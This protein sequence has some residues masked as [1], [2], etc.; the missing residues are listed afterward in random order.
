[1]PRNQESAEEQIGAAQAVERQGESWAKP[2]SVI[3]AQLACPPRS[4]VPLSSPPSRSLASSGTPDCIHF[5]RQRLT[6]RTL[7]P[8]FPLAPT[9][10][11]NTSAFSSLP[12]SP[13][14]RGTTVALLR[15]LLAPQQPL[16]LLRSAQ[17]SLSELCAHCTSFLPRTRLPRTVFAHPSRTSCSSCP[18]PR[19]P[20]S[21]HHPLPEPEPC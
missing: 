9:R 11:P 15:A 18:A 12:R 16:D 1:M 5:A 10:G 7:S 13:S 19:R 2:V 6:Q 21:T 14:S 17:A 8:S 4:S 20:H 3:L